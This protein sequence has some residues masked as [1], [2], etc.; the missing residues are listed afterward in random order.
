MASERHGK[1]NKPTISF[2]VTP[3]EQQVI[4][5][6]VRQSGM[7]KQ[8]Y[9]VRSCIYNHV[10]VV[11]KRENIEIIRSEAKEMYTVLEE[12]SKELKKDVPALSEEGLDSMTERYLAFL[13]SMLWMLNGAKYLWEDKEDEEKNK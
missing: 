5:E 11:G 9:I 4:E 10:C 8:D 3:Y 7:K 13:D 6:R 2:R 1:H 12:V